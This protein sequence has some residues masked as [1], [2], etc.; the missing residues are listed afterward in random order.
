M[1]EYGALVVPTNTNTRMEN[2]D[3]K[4]RMSGSYSS[5]QLKFIETW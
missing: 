1:I 2:K 4:P 3:W 5:T